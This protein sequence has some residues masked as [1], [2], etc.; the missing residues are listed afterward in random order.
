MAS[1]P[2]ETPDV[3]LLAC[4]DYDRGL[5]EE[6]VG[7]AFELLGGPGAFVGAGETVFVKNMYGAV[8]GMEKFAYHSRFRD[9]RDFA[10]LIVDVALAAKAD[11][12]VVDGVWGMEGNGSVW[13]TSRK[14]GFVA[15]GRDP[16]ALDCLVEDLV[17]LER[18][19]NRPLAARA[20]RLSR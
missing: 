8:P 14:L 4:S 13:G 1:V 2:R 9:E 7:R 10:D 6:K 15:A 5:V 3:A 18:G 19:F 12:H 20:R 16:F 11:L 17:G